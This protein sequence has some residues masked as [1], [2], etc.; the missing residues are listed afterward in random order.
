L[1][2]HIDQLC[3]LL[4]TY[5]PD[6]QFV[7]TTHDR[8]LGGADEICRSGHSKTSVAFHSWTIDTGPLVESS[9]EI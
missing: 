8:L 5:F 3:R 4:K 9:E 6:T 1:T 7:I 2:S